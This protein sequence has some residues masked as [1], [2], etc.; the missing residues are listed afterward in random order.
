MN[1]RHV[2]TTAIFA[3][4]AKPMQVAR[5][6]L[7]GEVPAVFRVSIRSELRV[8]IEFSVIEAWVQRTGSGLL[9]SVSQNVI[10][11]TALMQHGDTK[12]THDRSPQPTPAQ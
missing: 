3:S 4:A 10:V 12:S 7:Q 9:A 11:A 8:S 5:S 6:E 2:T 1:Y